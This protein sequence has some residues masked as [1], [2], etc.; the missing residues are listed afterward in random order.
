MALRRSVLVIPTFLR[1]KAH[2]AP[3]TF[4]TLSLL[5]STFIEKSERR[6][7]KGIFCARDSYLAF[8][9]ARKGLNK[10]PTQSTYA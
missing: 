3:P 7:R 9:R 8:A 10:I 6:F 2:E 5:W 1:V 4:Q